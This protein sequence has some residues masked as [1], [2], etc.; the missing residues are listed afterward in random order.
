MDMNIDNKFHESSII[1]VEGKTDSAV[2]QLILKQLGWQ[3]IDKGEKGEIGNYIF[4]KGDTRIQLHAIGGK[5]HLKYKKI[6]K[7]TGFEKVSKILVV[8]DADK[9]REKTEQSLKTFCQNFY[10][11][12]KENGKT[13][14]LADYFILPPEKGKEL[15]EYI[16][17]KLMSNSEYGE[18]LFNL[19]KC[20]RDFLS[21]KEVSK[22][23]KK[24]FYLFLLFYENCN[25]EGTSLKTELL[26]SCLDKLGIDFLELKTKIE[27]F[28][29]K[30]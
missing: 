19:E 1:V 3:L 6:K 2:I 14:I 8:R 5:T 9:D 7:V 15:E 25:Y 16:I 13:E 10:N 30:V 28:L 20:L 4:R 29:E 27:S 23:E 26:S 17:E 11:D 18:K 21:I 22:F 24:L 12:K